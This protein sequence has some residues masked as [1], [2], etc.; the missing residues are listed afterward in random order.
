VID[1]TRA[2]TALGWRPEIGFDKGIDGV[3]EWIEQYWEEIRM[4]PLD[5]V[6]QQ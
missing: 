1:S 2:R 6:H 4:K 5:Y 3:V